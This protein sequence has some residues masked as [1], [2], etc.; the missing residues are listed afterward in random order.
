MN[1]AAFTFYIDIV[2]N[3]KKIRFIVQF[4][5]MISLRILILLIS[6]FAKYSLYED[7]TEVFQNKVL[8]IESEKEITHIH[9][10]LTSII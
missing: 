10:H 6:S 9:I 4:V 2:K 8:H 1:V 7:C 5:M 3:C